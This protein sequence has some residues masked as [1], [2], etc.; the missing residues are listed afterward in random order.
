M[1]W[2]TKVN[3][4]QFPVWNN[5]EKPGKKNGNNKNNLE[6]QIASKTLFL[7]V[8]W[9]YSWKS[10]TFESG[11][12]VKKPPFTSISR[13]FPIHWG[14]EWNRKVEEGQIFCFCLSCD[15][16]LSCSQT[17]VLLV[18]E[19]LDSDWL[20]PLTLL[21]FQL[22]YGRSW[23]FSASSYIYLS[24]YP[25]IY[26]SIHLSIYL[27]TYLIYLIGF[28]STENPNTGR[29]NTFSFFFF[30]FGCVCSKKLTLW[31]EWQYEFKKPCQTSFSFYFMYRVILFLLDMLTLLG[32]KL[33][34][35]VLI[36]YVELCAKHTG[37][38]IPHRS[39]RISY[40]SSPFL[41]S[42]SNMRQN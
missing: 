2:L 39:G 34:T 17:W 31:P 35:L 18:F 26:L 38:S 3:K 24:I 4:T 21:A 15:I 9:G 32:R 36:L 12:W 5:I 19:L 25:S 10:L 28:I 6:A 14:P 13:N 30:F 1:D 37:E 11:D 42:A 40:Y 41:T 27:P 22:V 20:I 8:S 33:I 29:K 23:H 7:H 16:C